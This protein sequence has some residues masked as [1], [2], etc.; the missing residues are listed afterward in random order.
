MA[1]SEQ[2]T[3]RMDPPLSPEMIVSP[4]CQRLGYPTGHDR[5]RQIFRD[6]WEHWVDLRMEN[7]VP[8]DQR[9]Y[10]NKIVLRL[11]LCRWSGS[12]HFS[13][14]LNHQVHRHHNTIVFS[15]TYHVTITY[16][17]SASIVE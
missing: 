13:Y 6:H 17:H 4:S 3:D 14:I 1:R 10:V 7:E 16:F 11:M 8:V 2:P 5:F 15:I 9:A 12:I